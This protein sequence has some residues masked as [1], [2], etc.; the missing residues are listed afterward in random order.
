MNEQRATQPFDGKKGQLSDDACRH[1]PRESAIC[2]PRVR[3]PYP[4]GPFQRGRAVADIRLIDLT[5]PTTVIDVGANVGQ[6]AS[7]VLA[8]FG[9]LR[10]VSFEPEER[11]RPKRSAVPAVT[12]N[13][14]VVRSSRRRRGGGLPDLACRG[15]FPVFVAARDG[16][17]SRDRRAGVEVP[18]GRIGAPAGRSIPCSRGRRT[19]VTGTT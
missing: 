12:A 10:V 4:A 14:V 8:S 6:F 11:R 7:G 9:N 18:G 13:W 3:I 1:S 19:A 5:K 17:A 2:R 15:Q 16:G